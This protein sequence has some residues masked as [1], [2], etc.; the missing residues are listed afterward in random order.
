MRIISYLCLLLIVILGI[1]FASLN[2]TLVTINYY[3][4]VHL[5]PLSLL[6]AIVFALGCLLGILVSIW[7]LVKAKLR[8]YRLQQRYHVLEKEV[9]N[10][11]AIPLRE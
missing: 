4:G 10:L 9:E 7:L 2:S 6:L 5:L 8:Y 11:R 3:F 1:S